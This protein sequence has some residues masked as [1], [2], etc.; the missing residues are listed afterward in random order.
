MFDD[1]IKY[2]EMQEA[3]EKMFKEKALEDYRRELD[4]LA[5]SRRAVRESEKLAAKEPVSTSKG[6]EQS[7]DI[8][9]FQNTV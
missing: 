9:G 5:E 8:Q 4:A 6:P 7:D 3:K 1:G 2:E